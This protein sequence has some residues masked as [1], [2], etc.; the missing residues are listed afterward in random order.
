MTDAITDKAIRTLMR[1]VAADPI[2]CLHETGDAWGFGQSLR[3]DKRWPQFTDGFNRNLR[4]ESHFYKRRFDVADA[5]VQRCAIIF[6]VFVPVDPPAQRSEYFAGWVP[7]D[8][9]TDADQWITFLNAEIRDRLVTAGIQPQPP[10]PTDGI[11]PLHAWSHDGRTLTLV[12]D[13]GEAGEADPGAPSILAAVGKGGRL[14][15]LRLAIAGYLREQPRAILSMGFSVDLLDP[16]QFAGSPSIRADGV[17]AWH[18]TL[19][20][21]LDRD[22]VPLPA[23]FEEHVRERVGAGPRE[24]ATV[25]TAPGVPSKGEP[26]RLK[27]I[28]NYRELG[29][30]RAI[31]GQ[32]PPSLVA[33]RGKGR[34]PAARGDVAAYLRGGW[35]IGGRMG[36]AADVFETQTLAGHAGL[37]TD[38]AYAWP[39]FLGYYVERY[40]LALPAD[41][42]ERMRKRWWRPPMALDTSG[43]VRP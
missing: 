23:A 30:L 34:S 42:E 4:P 43:L 40:D 9:E 11:P 31:D 39:Q 20:H 24:A 7:L 5:G 35:E 32:P 8:R 41:F 25:Q 28:G 14:A 26:R 3:I 36:R 21:Y 10:G 13:Y 1:T 37:V 27:L 16:S 17:F 12:G 6:R 22:D 15:E 2:A 18:D 38:G 19:A 29:F 33:A